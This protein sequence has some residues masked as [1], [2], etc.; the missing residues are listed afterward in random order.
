MA[1]ARSLI[2]S[3][4]KVDDEATSFMMTNFYKK[5]FKNSFRI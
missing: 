1:G 5:L 3:L 2:M 4:W